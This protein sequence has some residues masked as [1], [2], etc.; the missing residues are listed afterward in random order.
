MAKE[1]ERL[2]TTERV[3][4]ADTGSA[5]RSGA[6]RH[7]FDRR[8]PGP[9]GCPGSARGG[10]AAIHSVDCELSGPLTAEIRNGLDGALGCNRFKFGLSE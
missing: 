9:L 10:G 2:A 8:G 3:V 6:A 1:L 5:K 4:K 7:S